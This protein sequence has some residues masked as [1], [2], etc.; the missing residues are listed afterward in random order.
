[1]PL[2]LVP[3]L[4]EL[5]IGQLEAKLEAIRVQR[6]LLRIQYQQAA[7]IKLAALG[8]KT[9]DKLKHQLEMFVKDFTSLDAALARCDKRMEQITITRNEVSYID[10]AIDD[11]ETE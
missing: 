10:D 11:G 5:S 3:A 7:N 1:M 8:R 9:R 2:E 6:L 4:E